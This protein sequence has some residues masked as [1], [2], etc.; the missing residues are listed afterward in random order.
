M[1]NVCAWAKVRPSNP[2][3]VQNLSLSNICP[4]NVLDLWVGDGS[5]TRVA[6][7]T[8]FVQ[9]PSSPKYVQKM[10][11]ISV[12]QYLDCSIGHSVDKSWIFLSNFCPKTIDLDRISTSVRQ[13]LDRPCTFLPLDR[14]WTECRQTLDKNWILCPESVHPLSNHPLLRRTQKPLC[15]NIYIQ[16]VGKLL[17]CGGVSPKIK[18]TSS[19]DAPGEDVV[20]S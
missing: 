16:S 18:Q 17:D 2:G 4:V 6:S 14:S 8:G 5:P 11:N 3:F 15:L 20:V 9:S 19:I 1:S 13:R 10:S 7:S 12:C